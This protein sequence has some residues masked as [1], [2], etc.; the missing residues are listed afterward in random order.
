MFSVIP[1]VE[2]DNAEAKEKARKSVLL[3]EKEVKKAKERLEKDQVDNL[4]EIDDDDDDD[5]K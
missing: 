2:S 5:D 4:Y 3:K 1:I